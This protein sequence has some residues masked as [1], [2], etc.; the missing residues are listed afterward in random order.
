MYVYL[1][2]YQQG[3]EP[4]EPLI[5]YVT[6]Y[7]GPVRAFETTPVV[8]TER[9]A[10]RLNTMPVKLN[11]PLDKLA[12]GEYRLQVTVLNPNSQKAAFWQ[13]QIMLAP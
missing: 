10:N 4:P 13:T 12:P 7:R 5:A 2:A 3:S 11:F 6:V 1:Q 8:V 9:V